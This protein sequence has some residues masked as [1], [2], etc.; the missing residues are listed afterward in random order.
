[1]T[2]IRWPEEPDWHLGVTGS[3]RRLAVPGQGQGFEFPTADQIIG[4][5]QFLDEAMDHGLKYVHHGCCTGW[6]EHTVR[7][8]RGANLDVLIYA[9]PPEDESF[10]SRYAMD[11]SDVVAKPKG[12][13]ERDFDIAKQSS[14][15]LAGPAYPEFDPRS[16]RS[17]T[18]LTMRFG[19]RL[20]KHLYAIDQQ[21]NV[22]D[23]TSEVVAG[24]DANGGK[25]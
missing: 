11:A 19:R 20:R 24:T 9:H 4:L 10:L 15:L 17:G 23:V 1:M 5:G 3:R 14:I 6:D 7:I 25:A 18:W 22:S 16:R 21:G 12:Y 13:H 8:C 2:W